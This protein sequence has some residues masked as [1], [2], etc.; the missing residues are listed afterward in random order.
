[1]ISGL[2]RPAL[3]PECPTLVAWQTSSPILIMG[4]QD[5]NNQDK[6]EGF[7]AAGAERQKAILRAAKRAR[8]N[9]PAPHSLPQQQAGASEIPAQPPSFNSQ[10][11]FGSPQPVDDQHLAASQPTGSQ[12]DH[13]AGIVPPGTQLPVPD[14]SHT[15]SEAAHPEIAGLVPGLSS[16]NGQPDRLGAESTSQPSE[17]SSGAMGRAVPHEGRAA[18]PVGGADG[19]GGSHLGGGAMLLV[20]AGS[21]HHSFHDVLALFSTYF[22]SILRTVSPGWLFVDLPHSS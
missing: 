18:G 9:S 15:F 3:L 16:V 14:P 11:G 22:K 17:S 13:H 2:C 20:L 5:W 4:S 1:M 8:Q 7:F 21:S 6:P 19:A 12:N 10:G